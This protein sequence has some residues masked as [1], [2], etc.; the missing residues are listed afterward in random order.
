MCFKCI[1]NIGG[2]THLQVHPF[3]KRQNGP[4]CQMLFESFLSCTDNFSSRRGN[5]AIM[6]W[7]GGECRGEAAINARK[8]E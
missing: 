8:D 4:F 2:T 6:R 5:L 7:P 1:L 3:P